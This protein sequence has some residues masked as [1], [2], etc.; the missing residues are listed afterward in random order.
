MAIIPPVAALPLE[1]GPL[2]FEFMCAGEPLSVKL[3]GLVTR[4]GFGEHTPS[5][6]SRAMW[7]VLS[8]PPCPDGQSHG[9]GWPSCWHT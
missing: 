9:M 4:A 2:A 7:I 8:A 1:L 6:I 3:D 5:V